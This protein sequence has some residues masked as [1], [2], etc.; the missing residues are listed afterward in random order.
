MGTLGLAKKCKT[1]YAYQAAALLALGCISICS[2]PVLARSEAEPAIPLQQALQSRKYWFSANV[3]EIKAAYTV[4]GKP[5]IYAFP[6]ARCNPGSR[7]NYGVEHYLIAL[8]LNQIRTEY[9]AASEKHVSLKKQDGA[10]VH[11]IATSSPCAG[12]QF[13]NQYL[14]GRRFL[15]LAD[16]ADSYPE[17]GIFADPGLRRFS[18]SEMPV[19]ERASTPAGWF[20]QEGESHCPAYIQS[21]NIIPALLQLMRE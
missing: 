3:T 16:T 9:I 18:F 7:L 10:A 14:L 1:H 5:G 2:A 13:F 11:V 20:V 21:I 12:M 4:W 17:D 6:A 15:F 19:I 8:K